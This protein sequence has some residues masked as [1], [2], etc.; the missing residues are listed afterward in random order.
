MDERRKMQM[1]ISLHAQ[2]A[3]HKTQDPFLIIVLF[4][5]GINGHHF[6]AINNVC[7]KP[8]TSIMLNGEALGV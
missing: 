1:L 4:E 5:V 3:L 2:K 6:N 8:K 7:V